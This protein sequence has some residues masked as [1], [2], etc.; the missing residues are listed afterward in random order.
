MFRRGGS[1][2]PARGAGRICGE[3]MG[4]QRV[5]HAAQVTD[6]LQGKQ[7]HPH[8]MSK[9]FCSRVSLQQRPGSWVPARTRHEQRQAWTG[10]AEASSAAHFTSR[11]N[12]EG[13]SAGAPAP[14]RAELHGW[15]C[16]CA[17]TRGSS[18]RPHSSYWP[19]NHRQT[20]E[21]QG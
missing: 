20:G 4:E 21:A 9:E 12:G 15:R 2:A 1:A 5:E 16:L 14:P 18:S 13:V 8:G 10:A 17:R 19:T 7:L 6:L 11:I 3:R